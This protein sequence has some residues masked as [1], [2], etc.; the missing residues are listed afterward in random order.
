MGQIDVEMDTNRI[1]NNSQEIKIHE[2]KFL[3]K[4]FSGNYN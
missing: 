4:M 3:V 2:N 1:I